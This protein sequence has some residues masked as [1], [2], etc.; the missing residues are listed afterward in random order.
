MENKNQKDE[1]EIKK[2][3]KEKEVKKEV[4][5]KETKTNLEKNNE[6]ETTKKDGKHFNK[7]TKWVTI[8]LSI[9]I[10]VATILGIVF[11]IKSPYFA[12]MKTFNSIKKGDVASI[13]NYISYEEIMNSLVV[14][15]NVED[16]M[17]LVRKKC[18]EEFR[19]RIKNVETNGDIAT[20]EIES[21]NK[22]FRNALAKLIQV[23]MQKDINDEETTN[24]ER[25][26]ILNE[27]LSDTTI[28]TM[29]VNKNI[30]L[31][32]VDGKW[33]IVL[34]DEI[35]DALFPGQS[36]VVNSIDALIGE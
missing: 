15:L 22:N 7:I 29:T 5:K 2:T 24:E 30:T 35:K 36:E 31:N 13:N 9:I 32:K 23:I 11:F 6:K 8:I 27:C 17:E 3:K 16:N 14:G 20:V 25:I 10:I 4:K 28:G 12:V 19:Y 26:T 1:K 33:K 18:F 21:T 34:D